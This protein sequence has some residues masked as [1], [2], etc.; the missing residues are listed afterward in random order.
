MLVIIVDSMLA[1]SLILMSWV[2]ILPNLVP[3]KI[4]DLVITIEYESVVAFF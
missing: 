2:Q 3:R 1:L 4:K